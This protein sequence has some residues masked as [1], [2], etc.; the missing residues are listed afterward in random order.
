MWAIPTCTGSVLKKNQVKSPCSEP[1]VPET[2]SDP[3]IGSNRE[4]G[5]DTLNM[6]K[7]ARVYFGELQFS[8]PYKN[9]V[10]EIHTLSCACSMSNPF[11]SCLL[12]NMERDSH[13]RHQSSIRTNFPI[14]IFQSGI[15]TYS[16]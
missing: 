7:N 15:G 2:G 10:L 12:Q 11:F 8:P 5:H 16:L 4:S 3:P 1:R 9:F 13:L 6:S 14:L